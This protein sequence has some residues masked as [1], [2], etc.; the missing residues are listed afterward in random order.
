VPDTSYAT[1]WIAVAP[2]GQSLATGG[3]LYLAN[4]DTFKYEFDG[5][6]D[7]RLWRLPESVWPNPRE[8]GQPLANEQKLIPIHNWSGHELPIN[9]VAFLPGG[10]RAVSVNMF[11]SQTICWDLEQ[12]TSHWKFDAEP[13]RIL[14]C[15]AVEVSPSGKRVAV[16]IADGFVCLLDA[17][18]GQEQVRWKAHDAGPVYK[19]D[20]DVSWL[21]WSPNGEMLASVPGGIGGVKLWNVKESA[22]TTPKSVPAEIVT[23][24]K[25][26]MGET[27][28]LSF[29]PA[30]DY[31]FAG[32]N[33]YHMLKIAAWSTG[34]PL[35][36][37]FVTPVENG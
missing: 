15:G 8:Q 14:Q 3:G 30:S 28:G 6:G 37:R 9:D 12:G 23:G 27:E 19:H 10:K 32:G 11:D 24:E 20:D 33:A 2:D 34:K 13:G 22:L 18:T 7:V 31:L 21:A 35:F 1:N 16:G 5:D 17:E 36:H 4:P 25:P 26:L 29:S